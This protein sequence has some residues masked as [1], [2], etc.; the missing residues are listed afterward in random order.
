MTAFEVITLNGSFGKSIVR[1]SGHEKVTGTATFTAEWPVNGLLHAVAVPSNVD[2]SKVKSID[3][4]VAESMPGKRLVL[5]LQ[6]EWF[7]L[8]LI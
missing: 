4:S 2:R 3:S 6:E 1:R 8:A 7:S 5:T